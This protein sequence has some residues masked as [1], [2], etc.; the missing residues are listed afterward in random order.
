MLS[1]CGAYTVLPAQQL[2]SVVFVS[3]GYLSVNNFVFY[4][5][6][7]M[8]NLSGSV[9]L[10]GEKLRR[11]YKVTSVSSLSTKT[12]ILFSLVALITDFYIFFSNYLYL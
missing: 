8:M 10:T 12:F 6:E 4:Y 1:C 2:E 3:R 9:N 11:F 5:P 7:Q